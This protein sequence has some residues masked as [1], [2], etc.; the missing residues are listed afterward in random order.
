[1][2]FST[3]FCIWVQ[4]GGGPMGLVHS[5]PMNFFSLYM[6]K[7]QVSKTFFFC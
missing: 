1:M 4:G 2:C 5:L 7:I 6:W 3:D